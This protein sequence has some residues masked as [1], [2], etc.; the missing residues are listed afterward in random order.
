MLA[1]MN[2][3]RIRLH[4]VHGTWAK[5]FGGTARAWSEPGDAAYERLRSQLPPN[6]QFE[7]FSWSGRNSIAAR[8]TAA[9]DLRQHL[10]QSLREHP[11]DRHIVLA[12]SHG[13]T[14]ANQAVSGSDLDGSIRGLICLA[15]PFAYL[16]SPSLRRLQTGILA[17]TSVLYATYWTVLLGC[18]PWIPE[19]LGAVVF[20]GVVAAKSLFAFCLVLFV[21]KSQ[22]GARPSILRPSGPQET[23]VF[24]L[25]GS[26]DEASLLLTGAQL[27]DTI[28]AAF[29]GL[30]DDTPLTI[31]RPLTWVNYAMVYASCSALGVYAAMRMA[32]LFAPRIGDDAVGIM[33]VFV[34]GPAVA[35]WVY[36]IGYAT[37]AIGAGHS[38]LLHWLLSAVEIEAAP[39]NTM[40]QMYVFSELGTSGLRHGLYEDDQVLGRVAELIQ[41]I[42]NPDMVDSAAS[43]GA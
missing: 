27:F 30:N 41:S 7:S 20:A 16:V 1:R 34:Y 15:T 42:E 29:A 24:L 13:G 33:G 40:C 23:S 10:R 11:K 28:C 6:S 14:V 3:T 9:N 26:R 5:G 38:N 17:L 36:L 18:M 35:G 4:L 19:F 31:R 2:A 22:Y 43:N 8:T 21:V 32:A 25:R 39:P 12:H 37:I